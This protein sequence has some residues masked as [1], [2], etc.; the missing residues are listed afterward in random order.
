MNI[1]F[2]KEGDQGNLREPSF[3]LIYSVDEKSFRV[4][5]AGPGVPT[6]KDIEGSYSLE[7]YYAIH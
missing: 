3:C 7:S 2:N 4:I 5:L 6:V 1:K